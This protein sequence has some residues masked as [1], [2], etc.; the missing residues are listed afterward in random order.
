MNLQDTTNIGLILTQTCRGKPNV[1]NLQSVVL[2]LRDFGEKVFLDQPHR[3]AQ[4]VAQIAHESGEFRYDREIWDG[5]GAQARYDSRTDL[6]NTAAIDGDGFKYRG[7]TGIQVTGKRNY[8]LLTS[9]VRAIN[10]AAPDFVSDPDLLNTDPWEGMAPIWFWTTNKLNKYADQGNVEMVT[11]TINGGLNGFDDRLDLLVRVSLILLGYAPAEVRRFQV[12]TGL[13]ADGIA[14]P[15]TRAKLH[16][17]L[18]K[19]K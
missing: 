10:P 5:K 17:Q 2:G 11:R 13:A 15:A 6:G 12:I 9:W 14:G 7:R 1:A 4:Y 16:E 18:V 3:F 8:A 19:T